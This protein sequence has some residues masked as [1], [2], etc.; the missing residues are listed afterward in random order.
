MSESVRK[1]VYETFEGNDLGDVEFSGKACYD[2]YGVQINRDEGPMCPRC[3]KTELEVDNDVVQWFIDGIRSIS[4]DSCYLDNADD[5]YE[6]EYRLCP[7]AAYG[8][9]AKCGDINGRI[10]GRVLSTDFTITTL[11]RDC[12]N[13]EAQQDVFKNGCHNQVGSNAIIAPLIEESYNSASGVS[14][15]NFEGQACFQP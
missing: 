6:V 12:V 5:I 1:L 15:Q 10:T 9:V 7:P 4:D 11:Q 14:N 8:Q 3:T 13:G 2:S